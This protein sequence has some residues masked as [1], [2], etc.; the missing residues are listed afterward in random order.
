MFKQY[1]KEHNL[2]IDLTDFEKRKFYIDSKA[3][4]LTITDGDFNITFEELE[5]LLAYLNSFPHEIDK[6]LNFDEL[7]KKY[8]AN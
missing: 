7:V 8:T 2:D 4:R 3:I 5:G 1:V 6:Q